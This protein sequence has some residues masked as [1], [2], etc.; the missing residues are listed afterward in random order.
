M[1]CDGTGR[2]LAARAVFHSLLLAAL[3]LAVL[4]SCGGGRSAACPP[5]QPTMQLTESPGAV[6]LP[7][8]SALRGA[9]YVPAE[10][11]RSGAGFEDGA[12]YPLQGA[13]EDGDC[14]AFSPDWTAG[15]L[16]PGALAYACYSFGM[17]GYDRAH[18]ISFLWDEAGA[19]A[20]L[21]VALPDWAS[22]R[23]VWYQPLGEVLETD[24][25]PHIDPETHGMLVLPVLT[26]QDDWRLSRL[27]V[28]DVC[29]L[30]GNVFLDDQ[31]TPMIG[32]EIAVDG[33]GAY[34]VHTNLS[35]RWLVSGALP[36]D[37]TVTPSLIGCVFNPA[38]REVTADRLDVVVE[39]FL[40]TLLPTHTVSGLV[41]ADPGA[42]PLQG[43]EMAIS[44]QDGSGGGFSAWTDFDGTWS[45]ELPDGDFK[46]VPSKVGWS[47]SPPDRLFSVSG[48]DL[49][50]D[51]FTG[52]ELPGHTLDGYVYLADG[53]T[54]VEDI[55]VT[56]THDVLELYYYDSTDAAGYWSVTDAPDGDYTVVAYWPGWVFKPTERHVTM[57]GADV[58]VEPFL[59]TE[60]GQFDIEGYVFRE[61]GVTPLARVSVQLS[62]DTGW[63]WDATDDDGYYQ[64]SDI[65]AGLCTITPSE[66]R[67]SFEPPFRE[68]QL[69]ADTTLDPFLATLLPTF[70]V[71]GYIYRED[72]TTP[73]DGVKVQVYSFGPGGGDFF[74]ATTDAGGYWQ[75][76]GVPPGYFT[77]WPNRQGYTFDPLDQAI[78]VEDADVT[79]DDFLGTAEPSYVMDGYVYE[80]DGV[81][82]VP[83]VPLTLQGLYYHFQAVTDA[84]G[85]WQLDEVFDDTYS[86][87]PMLAPWQFDPTSRIV[88]VSGAD[89][90]VPPFYGEELPAWLV[91]GYVYA[92]DTTNPVPDVEIWLYAEG[93]TYS[94]MTDSMGHYGMELPSGEWQAKPSG[95]WNFEPYMQSFT[96]AGEPL[97]LE[98]FY[99]TPGG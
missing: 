24:L 80:L 62:C 72:G 92:A 97:T 19:P 59:G 42:E 27:V 1:G 32:V 31:S 76:W 51:D 77:V 4:T 89:V 54:P 57:A 84:G 69:G 43:V 23:W 78:Q 98:V 56:V 64:F 38:S 96:V 88:E 9:A 15:S 6:E 58:R 66:M 94:C 20:D 65:H 46:V 29:I 73:V 35:G 67:Y 16:S 95:C 22:D 37:Y 60:V 50:V 75:V 45:A 30:S 40:G 13:V 41:V 25:T 74:E 52:T 11:L 83:G 79:V 3:M 82:G 48:A 68:F 49:L 10:L 2:G 21:W 8:P 33:P 61:D 63:F 71:D 99:A 87:W 55:Q 34:V 85:H 47:F 90:Y 28:G 81:T 86:I 36:G 12:G 7:P 39:D 14:C 53:V 5:D 93:F 26:G 70:C 17:T 18:T 91:D 44:P